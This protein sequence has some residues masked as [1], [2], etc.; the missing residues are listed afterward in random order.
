[1]NATGLHG[2]DEHSGQSERNSFGVLLS[3]FVDIKTVSKIDVDNLSGISLDHDVVWMSIT[4]TYDIPNNGHDRQWPDKASPGLEPLFTAWGPGPKYIFQVCSWY[5]LLYFLIYLDF[6]G[7]WQ[8]F[9]V[10]TNLSAHLFLEINIS[11]GSVLDD[12]LPDSVTV[13]DP[14]DY[15]DFQA[16][17]SDRVAL[18]GIIFPLTGIII[19]LIN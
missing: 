14:S 19:H 15:T 11:C 16:Y 8:Y 7:S 3:H 9:I 18:N 4:Q 5:P 6:L 12:E 1:M 10:L 13:L 2:L 17:W